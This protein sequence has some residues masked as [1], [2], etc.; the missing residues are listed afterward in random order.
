MSSNHPSQANLFGLLIMFNS[1]PCSSNCFTALQ[2]TTTD[3]DP[4]CL[5]SWFAC[6]PCSKHPTSDQ[7]VEITQMKRKHQ[8]KTEKHGK[9]NSCQET[10]SRAASPRKK[11]LCIFYK[12][13]LFFHSCKFAHLLDDFFFFSSKVMVNCYTYGN[14]LIP[15]MTYNLT[16]PFIFPLHT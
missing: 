16:C 2:K 15:Q 8:R 6:R 12:N 13:L 5:Q 11:E 4:S 3:T 10:L 9:H 7:P 1:V 14:S